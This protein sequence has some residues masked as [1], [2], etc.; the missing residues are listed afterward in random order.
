MAQS[1]PDRGTSAKKPTARR[2]I[3]LIRESRAGHAA[4]DTATSRALLDRASEGLESESLRLYRPG[5]LVAFGRQDV[6]SA[7]YGEAVA[8]A[9]SAGFAAVQRL[10]GGRPAVFHEQTISFS[11]TVPESQPREGI[12]RRYREIA[13]IIAAAFTNLGIDAQIGEVPGEYCPGAY[14]VNAR[15]VKKLMGVGQRVVARASYVGGVIV[16]AESGRIRDVLTPVHAALNLE[17]NPEATGSLHDEQDSVTYE[18]AEQAI[19]EE[20]ALRFELREGSLSPE[21]L[22]LAERYE[23]DHRSPPAGD[24]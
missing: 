13:E 1:G 8:A 7:G 5:P 12:Q 17:W 15:G 11:W 18:A 3:R 19:I 23:P 6:V 20:F 22:T 24:S 2:A 4:L 10:V 9:R 21:T 14:S 16:V